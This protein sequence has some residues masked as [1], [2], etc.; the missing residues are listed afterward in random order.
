MCV[1]VLQVAQTPP[2]NLFGIRVIC[3]LGTPNSDL[4]RSQGG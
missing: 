1:V 4:E 3:V 2:V